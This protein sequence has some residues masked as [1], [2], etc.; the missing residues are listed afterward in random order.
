MKETVLLRHRDTWS[1]WL[2]AAWYGVVWLVGACVVL[3]TLWIYSGIP[4]ALPFA[5]V[6]LLSLLGVP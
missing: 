2:S 4:W 5:M 6:I 1:Y 3:L